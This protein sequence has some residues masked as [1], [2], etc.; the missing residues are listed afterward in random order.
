MDKKTEFKEFVRKNPRLIT[1]VKNEKMSWQKFYEL[2]DLYG[3]KEDIW[4]EYLTKEERKSVD[5]NKE[6]GNDILGWMKGLDLDSIQNGMN[7]L[8]RVLALMTEL[9]TKDTVKTPKEEYK[10]RPLYKHF[11]D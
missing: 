2:Y 11:E 6:V 5:E 1:F 9:A 7:S 3:E 4:K 8:Q 10:P